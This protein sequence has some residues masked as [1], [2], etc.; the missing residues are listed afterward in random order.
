MN[1]RTVI[2]LLAAAT[3]AA[4]GQPPSPGT[5]EPVPR[6]EVTTTAEIP[7]TGTDP[8][9]TTTTTSPRTPPRTTT[10]TTKPTPTP[11][12]P[13]RWVLPSGLRG[14]IEEQDGQYFPEVWERFEEE[15]AKIC[16]GDAPCVGHAEVIDPS[17][18]DTRDCYIVDGGI[19]VPDPLYRGG[20]I[21]FRI[22]NDLCSGS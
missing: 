12:S 19:S 14:S 11:K 4:C 18:D 6:T 16:P 2:C 7:T 21:T 1:R 15:V 17:S 13:D 5:S 8:A 10:T 3:L 20:K 9:T 22:T